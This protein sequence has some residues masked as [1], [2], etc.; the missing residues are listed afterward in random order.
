MRLLGIPIETP[1]TAL[2]RIFSDLGALAR[3]ARTAPGQVERLLTLGEEIAATGRE[4]LEVAR[5]LDRH[6]EAVLAVGERLDTRG[7]EL[8]ELGAR[9]EVIGGQVDA[10]GA[11]IV[12]SADQ[13]GVRGAEIVDSAGQVAA[14]GSEL[15]AVLPTLERA[16]QMASPLEGAIDRFGRLVDRLPGGARRQMDRAVAEAERGSAGEPLD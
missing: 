14:T 5:R 4:V 1:Q 8:L 7:L 9:M 10:R 15:I 11:E 6:A 16:L 13:V 12:E 3:L 2:D